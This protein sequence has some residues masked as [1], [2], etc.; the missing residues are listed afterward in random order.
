MEKYTLF[1]SWQSDYKDSSNEIESAIN[2]ATV[3]LRSEGIA[4]I[5]IEYS[6]KGNVGMPNIESAILSKIT[7]CDIFVADA[8]PIAKCEKGHDVKSIPNPNVMV[9][10]GFAMSQLGLNRIICAAMFRDWSH[11]QLPFDIN[12]RKIKSFQKGNLSLFEEIK[13]IARDIQNTFVQLGST[14]GIME[15]YH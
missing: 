14:L 1:F 4:D 8:T 13:A 7:N 9:E 5:T 15:S 10:L 11:N 12:H 2:T 3:Q 6:T